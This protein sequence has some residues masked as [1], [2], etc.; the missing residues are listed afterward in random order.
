MSFATLFSGADPRPVLLIGSGPMAAATMRRLVDAGAQVRWFSQNVDIAED[1]WLSSQPSR[2]KLAFREPRAADFEE[3]AAVIATIG[4][5]LAHRLS[6]QARAAGCPVSVVGRPDLSTLDLDAEP[7][8]ECVG[9]R[10]PEV[11][12]VCR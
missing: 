3:A 10:V 5:P 12:G 8:T 1:I 2:V 9:A 6:E 4:E 7:D 11:R